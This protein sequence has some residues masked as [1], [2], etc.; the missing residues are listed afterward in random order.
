MEDV[1]W[2]PPA[3]SFTIVRHGGTVQGS[4]RADVQQWEVNVATGSASWTLEGRRQLKLLAPR[5]D[6]KA[7]AV[8]IKDL[9]TNHIE[10]PRLK[11]NRDGS[12]R[13]MASQVFPADSAVKQTVAGRRRRFWSALDD[14]LAADGWRRNGRDR[15]RITVSRDDVVPPTAKGPMG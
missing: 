12:V 8:C 15:Y 2:H 14:L 11:W 10:D 7:I 3:L 1:G 5:V 9:I 4:T 6:V 13:V